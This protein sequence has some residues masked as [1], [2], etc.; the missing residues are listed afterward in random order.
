VEILRAGDVAQLA[1]LE[2]VGHVRSF[3]GWLEW[4]S[5]R[6]ECRSGNPI[7][8]GVDGEA[9]MLQSPL[10]FRALPGALR[11]RLPVGAPSRSPSAKTLPS[12]QWALVALVKTA[13]G[14]QSPSLPAD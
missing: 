10:R 4:E 11:V 6:F 1:A 8:V 13:G 14:G 9:M 2:A 12:L 7:E 5:P 3:P